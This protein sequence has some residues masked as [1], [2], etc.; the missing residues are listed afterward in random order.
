[1]SHSVLV[2]THT[3]GEEEAMDERLVPEL[4]EVRYAFSSQHREVAAAL[5]SGDTDKGVQQ[6]EKALAKNYQMAQEDR[7]SQ[8]ERYNNHLSLGNLYMVQGNMSAAERNLNQAL[9]LVIDEEDQEEWVGKQKARPKAFFDLEEGEGV[10]QQ[11]RPSSLKE[12]ERV[13]QDRALQERK[14]KKLLLHNNLGVVKLQQHEL[15]AAQGWFEAAL[16]LAPLD[17]D[18]HN[19][20][21]LVL[22]QLAQQQEAGKCEE[23]EAIAI[24]HFRKA[25]VVKPTFVDAHLNL[26]LALIRC[27]ISEGKISGQSVGQEGDG[28]GVDAGILHLAAALKLQPDDTEVLS[29]LEDALAL[30]QDFG[31]VGQSVEY[32]FKIG[33]KLASG[34]ILDKTQ[35]VRGYIQ[36]KHASLPSTYWVLWEE[37][38]GEREAVPQTQWTTARAPMKLLRD[39]T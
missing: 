6:I 13:E 27:A 26:G 37:P 1:M 16:K 8:Q 28:R 20:L 32:T 17:H 21:G 30:K 38:I 24:A 7:M 5:R 15:D 25:I 14:R 2:P 4:D 9:H 23:Q 3:S 10:V 39:R 12:R 36:R 31:H 35:A 29:A 22:Q 18:A 33:H 11:P 34:G 19:N